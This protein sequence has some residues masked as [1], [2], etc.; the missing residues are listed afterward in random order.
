MN[1]MRGA[2]YKK[3]RKIQLKI[4]KADFYRVQGKGHN[5]L[6]FTQFHGCIHFISCL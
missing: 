1:R 4:V 5:W 3:C 6:R 2:K